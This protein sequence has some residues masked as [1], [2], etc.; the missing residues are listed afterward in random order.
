MR[1][2]II[3]DFCLAK[4]LDDPTQPPAAHPVRPSNTLVA[5]LSP[6]LN[7]TV[8]LNTYPAGLGPAYIQGHSFTNPKKH[9]TPETRPSRMLVTYIA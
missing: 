1:H 6:T 5:R 4:M 8:S 2:D 9:P 7:R 3:R